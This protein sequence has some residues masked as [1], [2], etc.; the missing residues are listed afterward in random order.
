MNDYYVVQGATEPLDVQISV[1]PTQP[2]AGVD[3]TLEIV[4]RDG[5]VPAP[6]P[7][8]EWLSQPDWTVRLTNLGGLTAS[9]SPYRFRF[10][11]T[12]GGSIGFAPTGKYPER[13]V[14][15]TP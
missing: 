3:V 4:D 15:V 10:Q 9:R 1:T 14:V 2:S 11:L 8:V 12:D 5:E 7:T 6:A 13:L